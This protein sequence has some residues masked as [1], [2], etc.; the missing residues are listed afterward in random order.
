MKAWLPTGEVP[1]VHGNS[2]QRAA[3]CCVCISCKETGLTVLTERADTCDMAVAA[4]Q[5][6]SNPSSNSGLDQQG[7]FIKQ[8]AGSC[9]CSSA[10]LLL[11]T[12]Q[13]A[14]A[15]CTLDLWQRSHQP[16]QLGTDRTGRY[17]HTTRS[18]SHVTKADAPASEAWGNRAISLASK[19]K[20]RWLVPRH[21]RR[22]SSTV[23]SRTSLLAGLSSR[24][25]A[26]HVS[27]SQG[28]WSC[29]R[30]LTDPLHHP[31]N[32]WSLTHACCRQ[33]VL[34][35]PWQQISPHS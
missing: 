11:Q 2:C 8:Q 17:V 14:N 26:M 35:R 27:C 34:I 16:T 6:S 1:A 25:P 18:C 31:Q 28:L 9:P 29:H 10:L 32:S 20:R 21:M 19:R 12:K 5:V 33:C 15:T 30:P 24:A 4:D 3:G 23:C 7:H 13:S 22:S